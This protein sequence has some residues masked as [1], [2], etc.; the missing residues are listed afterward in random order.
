MTTHMKIVHCV[1]H[2][3]DADDEGWGQLINTQ[4]GKSYRRRHDRLIVLKNATYP[5]NPSVQPDDSF[6]GTWFFPEWM[7]ESYPT[8]Q[9]LVEE[10]VDTYGITCV[11][12]QTELWDSLTPTTKE[13][14]SALVHKVYLVSHVFQSHEGAQYTAFMEN[15][16]QKHKKRKKPR[17]PLPPPKKQRTE[18]E[19]R[20][21]LCV[22]SSVNPPF[23]GRMH[24]PCLLVQPHPRVA[25]QGR[26]ATSSAPTLHT[27]DDPSVET[28][29][30]S[31]KVEETRYDGDDD[32]EDHHFHASTTGGGRSCI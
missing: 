26:C 18:R 23:H 2:I 15:S 9:D 11:E 5:F 27:H 21:E 29:N 16:L 12:L 25:T 14:L 6:S 10:G 8:I 19:Q 28:S 24:I 20:S 13:D 7:G 32:N 17:H 3:E 1:R 4:S 30:M 22:S 31:Q